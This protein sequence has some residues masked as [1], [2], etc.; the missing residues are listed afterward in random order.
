[1][2]TS[3]G[4]ATNMSHREWKPCLC[5]GPVPEQNT[6][7]GKAVFVQG[8]R[9]HTEWKPCLWVAESLPD[10]P[11]FWQHG[12]T[13]LSVLL[14]I[15]WLCDCLRP[16]ELPHLKDP[17]NIALFICLNFSPSHTNPQSRPE[18]SLL[19]MENN[20]CQSKQRLLESERS[21]GI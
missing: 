3:E 16:P 6:Q 8:P 12:C 4:L 17:V 5:K 13:A 7:R 9:A 11:E 1:M 20:C 15:Y 21:M 10:F 14:I 18:H 19:I 2:A